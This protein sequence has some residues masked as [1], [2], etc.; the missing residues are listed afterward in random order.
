[1]FPIEHNNVILLKIRGAP[2]I[3]IFGGL[4]IAIELNEWNEKEG[5]DALVLLVKKDLDYLVTSR[6][7][8]VNLANLK[9]E[10]LEFLEKHKDLNCSTL[11]IK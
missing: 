6:P 2:A 9:I 7:T 5:L 4:S 8:A 10:M 3:A 1:M 11:K